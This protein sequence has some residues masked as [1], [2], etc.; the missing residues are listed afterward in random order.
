MNKG[1]IEDEMEE[2]YDEMEE[3]DEEM[4][5][6]D[7]TA[8]ERERK[9]QSDIDREEDGGETRRRKKPIKERAAEGETEMREAT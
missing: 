6:G 8:I 9:R 1:E 2:R 3:I 4:E 7:K 5:E